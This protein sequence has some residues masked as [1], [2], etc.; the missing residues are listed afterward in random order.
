MLTATN[1]SLKNLIKNSFALAFVAMK[2]NIIILA[3][4]IVVLIGMLLLFNYLFPVF[5]L[6]LPFFPAAFLW[7]VTCFNSYPV[8][9]KYVI[10]PYYT[11]IGEVNPELID[12]SSDDE[13]VFE[14]MG[15]KEKPIEKRKKTKGKRI[16]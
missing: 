3:I 15:G 16:S 13:A 9:Q 5:M 4:T 11:S 8:I 7:F 12:D 6:L 10:N 14:D 1:L 2:S